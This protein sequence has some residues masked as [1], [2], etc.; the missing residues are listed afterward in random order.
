MDEILTRLAT[1][2]LIIFA[3]N[4]KLETVKPPQ[5]GEIVLKYRD[6]QPYTVAVTDHKKI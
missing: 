6:G 5:F 1:D 4:G 3:K 2:G